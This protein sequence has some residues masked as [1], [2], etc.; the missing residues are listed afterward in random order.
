[1]PGWAAG[2]SWRVAR[3]GVAL[4]CLLALLTLAIP[5]AAKKRKST[6]TV[7]VLTAIPSITE[8]TKAYGI[9]RLT[10]NAGRCVA[11]R[12]VVVTAVQTDTTRVKL[13]TARTSK[14]GAWAVDAPIEEF[15]GESGFDHLIAKAKRR[16]IKLRG[17]RN[18]L[19]CGP[20]MD[21][22]PGP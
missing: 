10:A 15:I 7:E 4:A 3:V 18:K 12:K 21:A 2:S 6:S 1:V 9:G 8:P 11:N 19:V 17:K 16:T 13:G 5:A 14:G 20:A 22:G